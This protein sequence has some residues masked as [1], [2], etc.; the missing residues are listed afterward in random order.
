[1]EEL[2]KKVAGIYIRVSTEDQAREG[3]SLPEQEERLQALCK[4]KGYKA[5]KV[6]KDAGISAKTGNKRPAF[7]ELLQDVKEKNVNIVVALKLD[8]LTRSVMDWEKIMN[9]LEENDAYIDC[10][11]DEINT[12]TANGKMISRILTSV[13]QQEIE[14][15]SERTKIG[16]EGAIKQGHIPHV[17]PLGYK[18]EDKKL[19]PDPA[20]KDIAIGIFND[21]YN[22]LSYNTIANKLNKEQVL[23]KTNWKDST[24]FAIISNEIYK[25]DFVHGKRTKTPTYYENVVEPLVPKELWEDCQFQKKNNQRAYTRTLTYTYLQKIKCPKCGRIMGGK[26]TKKKNGNIYY[27]YYCNDCKLNFKENIIEDYFKTFIDDIVNYDE[28]VNQFFLPMVIKTFN[29]PR[30]NIE[31][32]INRQNQ[33]LERLKSAYLDGAFNLDDFKS[34]SKSIKTAI[35]NLQSKLDESDKQDDFNYTS[36]DILLKRDIDYINSNV[37]K[38]E[39]SKNIKHWK[40]LSREEKA[41]LVMRYVDNIEVKQAGNS[42][43]VTNVNFRTSICKPC[44]DLYLNGYLDVKKTALF[45]NVIG[46][47]RFSEYLPEKEASEIIMRLKKYYDVSYKEAIYYVKD[48]VFYFNFVE[49][50][51]AIVRVFPL[52]DYYKKD[53][54]AEMEEYRF[55]I[56]YIKGA[57]QVSFITDKNKLLNYI[58]SNGKT[59][60]KLDSNDLWLKPIINNK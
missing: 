11:M 20:T 30:A 7:E 1:M 39:Y 42:Y 29:E 2:T 3:F 32:E 8:R 40:D 51:S 33:K 28:I 16:L 6:Y 60:I 45:G 4:Y 10:A 37:I 25:G 55:G 59:S 49:D 35:D 17:A 58:P 50:N 14:R 52:E 54:K 56:I 53:P 46:T 44:N 15:T 21:Y 43:E 13:S 18:H 19:V 36:S 23:G 9:F 41:D 38:D 22:G 24:I 26:A 27:Y 31:R 48:Q 5:Y 34:N 57:N 12:T 47:L